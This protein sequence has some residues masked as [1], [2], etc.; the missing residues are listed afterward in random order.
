MNKKWS[1]EDLEAMRAR[2]KQLKDGLTSTLVRDNPLCRQRSC[3]NCPLDKAPG[4][5]E[6]QHPRHIEILETILKENEPMNKK[7][8]LDGW[9][10]KKDDLQGWIDATEESVIRWEKRRDGEIYND[11]CPLCTIAKK[12]NPNQPDCSV[13]PLNYFSGCCNEMGSLWRKVRC[14]D[15]KPERVYRCNEMVKALKRLKKALEEYE[16]EKVLTVGDLMNGDLAEIEGRGTVWM[17]HNNQQAREGDT[18]LLDIQD[19]I[20]GS[21]DSSAKVTRLFSSLREA[22]DYMDQQK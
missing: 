4:C 20:N 7:N 19:G 10:C 14:A 18:T 9:K 8:T 15:S 16:P 6:D 3:G 5:G 1:E 12:D 11:S 13:C 22:V 17:R 2:L 21:V